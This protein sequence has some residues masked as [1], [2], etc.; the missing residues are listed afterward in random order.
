LDLRRFLFRS[1]YYFRMG[2]NTYLAFFLGFATTVVTVYYLA[3]NSISFLKS[4]FPT[5]WLFTIFGIVIGVPLCVF[6]GLWHFKRSQA[7]VS[8]ADIAVEANP[9]YYKY[10]P[11]YTREAWGPLFEELLMHTSRLLEAN[12][13][14]RDEDKARIRSLEEKLKALNEGGTMGWVKTP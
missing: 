3:I 9:W 10:P 11:G 6:S 4:L 14:L 2:Y 8:E 12:N 5:F 13:L 7:F 1:W